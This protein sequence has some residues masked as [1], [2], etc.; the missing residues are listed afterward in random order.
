MTNGKQAPG[1]DVSHYKNQIDWKRVK[2][3][4]VT[5]AVLKCTESDNFVDSRFDYNWT[6]ARR[7]GL[8][9][10]AYHFFRPL[11]DPVA[12]AQHFLRIAG[13][14]LHKTDL[15]P[16]LDVEVYPDFIKNEYKRI[17]SRERQQRV[18]IWLQTVEAATGRLPIIYTEFYTWRDFLGNN[19]ELTRY[20]LWI[21]NYKVERPKVPA[22]N[23][24]GRGWTFWQHTNRGVVPG[25]RDEAACV[26]LNY[27]ISDLDSLKAS[28]KIDAP[29]S[30]PPAITNGDMMAGLIDAADAQGGSSDEWVARTK[31]RYLVD[32]IGNSLRPY[33]GPAIEELPLNKREKR[34]LYKA[35][36]GY[37]LNFA[38][39]GI[40]HQDMVNAFYYAA[41]LGN[42]GGWDLVEKAGLGYIGKNR[43]Q[44]YTGPA[45]NELH[46]LSWAQKEAIAAYLGVEEINPPESQEEVEL[47]EEETPEPEVEVID[48]GLPPTYGAEMDNQAVI[49]AFYL[50]ALELDVNGQMMIAAAGLEGLGDARKL[51]YSGP[52]IEDLPGLSWEI[53]VH[54]AGLLNVSIVIPEDQIN[55][56]QGEGEPPAE[57]PV[58]PE[59]EPA[60]EIPVEAEIEEELVE[61][62]L[63]E[64][65]PPAP[66]VEYPDTDHLEDQL[67]EVDL[68]QPVEEE[69][70][71]RSWFPTFS[72]QEV[73]EAFFQAAERLGREG[74]SLLEQAGLL[75]LD[76]DRTGRFAGLAAEK[77]EQ[78]G[79]DVAELVVDAL[80]ID[81]KKS[82][83]KPPEIGEPYPGL[84]NLDIINL[85]HQAAANAGQSGQ[86]WLDAS[87]MAYLNKNRASRFKPYRG[88]QVTEFLRLSEQQRSA[89]QGALE[90]SS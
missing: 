84:V 78:I 60:V 90:E 82:L 69:K 64:V 24:G 57:T 7:V 74:W 8:I 44:I 2:E 87:G 9:R 53:K 59:P 52:I 70:E 39:L 36:E 41:S 17:S 63:P 42:I 37:S 32:P 13:D 18:K 29:R 25:I 54:L 76:L 21:A 1:I 14:I 86:Q 45:L 33:D 38:A 46:S 73:I 6:Q 5:Y 79:E 48:P 15:P 31:L 71:E 23:W 75:D 88:P 47:P 62:E 16:V 83:A 72:N 28:L 77:I 50:M 26:D 11:A 56:D 40:T 27:Y 85:F 30:V 51:V 43:T 10:G 22:E 65:I 89:L 34:A 80:G 67:P 20:P 4:G 49:N 58:E 12:Q 19:M 35:I 68:T 61:L 81:N 55:L 66:T 3:S